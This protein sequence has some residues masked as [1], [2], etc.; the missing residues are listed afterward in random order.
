MILMYSETQKRR[1]FAPIPSS[2][3]PVSIEWCQKEDPEETEGLHL[4]EL[5]IYASYRS[6][7]ATPHESHMEATG[8]RRG[9][10]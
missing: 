7:G 8:R 6:A 10:V 1:V 2:S 4:S 9:I 5:Q 3:R